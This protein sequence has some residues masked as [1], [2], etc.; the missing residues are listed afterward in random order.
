MFGSFFAMGMICFLRYRFPL[1]I[2]F[3]H[4]LRIFEEHDWMVTICIQSPYLFNLFLKLG[5]L[6]ILN[7]D[8]DVGD[9]FFSYFLQSRSLAVWQ[10]RKLSEK[11]RAK[12]ILSSRYMLLKVWARQS[13]GM[14]CLVEV[15]SHFPDTD[16]ICILN[17]TFV[18][19]FSHHPQQIMAASNFIVED[20]SLDCTS[21]SDLFAK[22]YAKFDLRL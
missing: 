10:A 22:N 11:I 13:D 18:L 6:Q 15:F 17:R 1:I 16:K 9:C 20:F 5:F 14:N 8:V 21:D 3:L 4:V 12:G 19:T 7:C 2:L